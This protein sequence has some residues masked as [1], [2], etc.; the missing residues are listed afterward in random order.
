M[1]RVATRAPLEAF[2]ALFL[3]QPGRPGNKGVTADPRPISRDAD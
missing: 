2:I 1:E 3:T